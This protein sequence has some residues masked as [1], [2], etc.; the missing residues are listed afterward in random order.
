MEDS[1]PSNSV[2]AVSAERVPACCDLTCA[3]C[4]RV[5]ML[6]H[7]QTGWCMELIPCIGFAIDQ[8]GCGE[9]RATATELHW[10]FILFIYL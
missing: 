3:P 2:F 10:V 4:V 1:E 8:G 6:V 7:G 5:C 9:N